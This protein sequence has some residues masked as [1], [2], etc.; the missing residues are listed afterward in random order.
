MRREWAKGGQRWGRTIRVCLS[1]A[2]SQSRASG[3]IPAVTA[4]NRIA[5]CGQLGEGDLSLKVP[6]AVELVEAGSAPETGN[7]DREKRPKPGRGPEVARHGWPG[8]SKTASAMTSNTKKKKK[9]CTCTRE[10]GSAKKSP[11]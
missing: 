4:Q 1:E 7:E 2:G 10:P 9:R 3:D 5:G 11:R 6:K 8:H